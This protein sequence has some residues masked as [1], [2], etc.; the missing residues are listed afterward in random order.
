VKKYSPIYG[1]DFVRLF[2]DS[3][4][5]NDRGYEYGALITTF[6]SFEELD[7]V[8]KLLEEK[9]NGNNT[10]YWLVLLSEDQKIQKSF[11]KLFPEQLS[12]QLQNSKAL[13]QR[14]KTRDIRIEAANDAKYHQM[15]QLLNEENILV[16]HQYHIAKESI[17]N[18]FTKFQKRKLKNIIEQFLG[19][20]NPLD[21]T[22]SISEGS[23]G[24]QNFSRQ[25][26]ITYSTAAVLLM[27]ELEIDTKPFRQKIF[28]ILPF[29][30][31]DKDVDSSIALLPDIQDSEIDNFAKRYI[32]PREDVF[33][34][35]SCQRFLKLCRKLN[36]SNAASTF[37]KEVLKNTQIPIHTRIEAINYL[38]E[39]KKN[40]D[41]IIEL[42]KFYESQPSTEDT[43]M[44][45]IA[46][47]DILLKFQ[48]ETAFEWRTKFILLNKYTIDRNNMSFGNP[49]LYLSSP[50]FK[51]KML[52]LLEDSFKILASGDKYYRFVATELWEPIQHFFSLQ[53]Q[54]KES[55]KKLLKELT[56]L[57]NKYDFVHQAQWFHDRIEKLQRGYMA[58]L[59]QPESFG[60]AIK[61]YNFLKQKQYLK[62]AS[63][64]ELFSIIKE[65]INNEF[66]NFINQ[67]FYKFIGQLYAPE[68]ELVP[69]ETLIQKDIVIKFENFLFKRGLR[70][71]DIS[72]ATPQF[73]REVQTMAD[74]RVDLII[75][76]GAIGSIMVEI[77]RAENGDLNK[78]NLAKYRDDTFLP[79]I[80]QTDCAFG[81]FLIFLDKEEG[82]K[83][84]SKRINEVK[85]VYAAFQNIEVIGIDCIK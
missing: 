24:Y 78:S 82:K 37:L 51:S 5:L 63:S 8:K 30:Y 35:E 11:E 57:T 38:F 27:N 75:S 62:I 69:R 36:I 15:V 60:N 6:V 29:L 26:G 45:L 83:G 73:Y 76:Y 55:M 16:I 44:L 70:P 41:Y 53:R 17:K 34:L 59:G 13:S 77:K 20:Y 9:Q 25:W 84:F 85:K 4:E 67:G 74:K 2:I 7:T 1:V 80:N 46:L 52:S 68:G 14:S 18:K 3:K 28:D 64:Q 48:N 61:E 19:D 21:S 66:T 49:L 31:S 33:H 58:Y 71:S 65:V 12:R 54:N 22:V 56:D 81:I 42:F 40:E 23:N 39:I 79:Y 43:D 32:K 72:D 10:F 47:N 50:K